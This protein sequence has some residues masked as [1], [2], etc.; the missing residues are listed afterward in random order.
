MS[1]SC[2]AKFNPNNYSDASYL[3]G[4]VF[5]L[6]FAIICLYSLISVKDY[7][8]FNKKII[9]K[10]FL[11]IKSTTVNLE[12]IES[13]T[14]IKKK[15]KNNSW[16]ILSLFTKTGTE[17]KISSYYYVNYYEIKTKIVKNKTRNLKIEEQKLN[18]ENKNYAVGFIVIGVIFLFC[19]YKFVQIKDINSSDIIVFGDITSENIELIKG[20]KNS[21]KVIIKLEKYPDF[22]FQI[23]GTTLKETYTQDLINDVKDGDSIYLGINKKEFRKKLIKIDSLTLIDK[24]FHYEIIH[25]ESIKTSKFE[26]LKLAE[27]NNGRNSNKYWGFGFFG[28]AGLFL[29]LSGIY[30]F[31][32]Y[33]KKKTATNSGFKKLGF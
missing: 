1:K 15:D 27:N 2:Y 29:F 26:Y 18:K 3:I 12:E 28:I 17:I 6:L 13:W 4:V 8:V 30:M 14:E 23:S 22:N 31:K 5:F 11:G 10:S 32:E 9:F 21:N 19:A 24:Y 16:E 25:I 33:N 20:R 7:Y